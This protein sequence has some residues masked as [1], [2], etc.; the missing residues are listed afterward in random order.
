MVV[1]A[2]IFITAWPEGQQGN[3]DRQY[4]SDNLH[5]SNLT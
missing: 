2:Q 1:I 5:G 3:V 4:M